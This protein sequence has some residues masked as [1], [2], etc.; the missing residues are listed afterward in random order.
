MIVALASIDNS[1]AAANLALSL[2]ALRTSSGSKVL[3]VSHGRPPAN[4]KLKTDLER[5]EEDQTYDDIVIDTSD[6][7][8][9]DSVAA[10]ASAGVIVLL[11]RPTEL[12]AQHAA[13]LLRRI[14]C[15]LHGNPEAQVLVAVGHDKKPLSAHEVGNILVF[16]AQI[17]SAR[18]VDTLV[19]DGTGAYHPCHSEAKIGDFGHE[20]ALCATEI[21]HLYGQVFRNNVGATVA[22]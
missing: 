20:A 13:P 2:A 18:L 1:P 16:V 12:E 4:E 11:I 19:L 3:L 5:F 6:T 15:A 9:K 22:A 8:S 10:L 7:E 14:K 17:S 21:R